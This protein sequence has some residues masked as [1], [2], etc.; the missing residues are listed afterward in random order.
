MNYKKI[1]TA[2]IG[3]GMISDIYLK[4]L[5]EKFSVIDIDS[6]A[7]RVEEKAREKSEKYGIKM[8]SVETLLIRLHITK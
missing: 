8:R 6:C 2:V 1:K 4:N 7:D 5:K 3:C